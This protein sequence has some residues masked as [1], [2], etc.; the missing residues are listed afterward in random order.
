MDSFTIVMRDP[1]APLDR[2]HERQPVVL[3]PEDWATWLDPSA[4][5]Q[6]LWRLDNAE[7][8]VVELGVAAEN[9]AQDIEM[10]DA[11]GRIRTCDQAVMSGPL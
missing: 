4:D 6:P 8:F 5:A 10:I 2:F 7:R 3:R 9:L 1:A 11:P